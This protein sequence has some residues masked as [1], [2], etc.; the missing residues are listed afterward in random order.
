MFWFGCISTNIDSG[1]RYYFSCCV[2]MT[3]LFFF[4][5][6]QSPVCLKQ[7]A[8]DLFEVLLL[9]AFPELDYVF[10]QLQEERHK[11]VESEGN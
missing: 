1:L 5:L 10:K 2:V 7:L 9:S 6:V 8:F 4:S 11:F 3:F